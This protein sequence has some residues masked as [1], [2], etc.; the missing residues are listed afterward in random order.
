PRGNLRAVEIVGGTVEGISQTVV[1]TGAGGTVKRIV[2]GVGSRVA[3]NGVVAVVEPDGASPYTMAKAQYDQIK[4]SYERVKALADEGAVPQETID[5]VE[6]AY[7][8]AREQLRAARKAE[9]VPAPFGG[10]VIEVYEQPKSKVGPG[11][12]IAKIA[13]WDKIR[14]EIEVNERLIS[15]YSPGQRAYIVAEGDTLWGEIEKVALGANAMTH[16]FPVWAVFPNPGLRIKPGAYVVVNVITRTAQSALHVPMDVVT[17]KEDGA[18]VYTV[19]GGVARRKIV[20][21]GLRSEGFLE[22]TEGLT[23]GE[24]VVV[25]GAS[26]LSDG[27][28]V[29]IV[30]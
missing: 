8:A 29:R 18:W 7:I 13:R 24:K 17:V 22:I 20:K 12:P 10:T 4:K 6:A 28:K 5:Q 9:N 30:N 3:E 23:E 11:T 2:A 16:A 21:H 1:S 19:T 15:N 26:L 25:R 27:A 14:V